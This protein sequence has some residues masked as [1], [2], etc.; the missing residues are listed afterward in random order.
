MNFVRLP[1]RWERLQQAPLGILDPFELELIRGTVANVTGSGAYIALDPHNY[2]RYQLDGTP[3][4][5][6][7]N[8]SLVTIADFA[9][10]WTR[11]ATE[12]VGNPRVIFALMNEPYGMP[13]M[14]WA[15]AAQ[16]AIN[17]IR[18]TGAKQ[19]IFVP[20]NGYTG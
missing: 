6:G 4:I 3:Q 11:L 12:F 17:A 8:T 16:A 14:L 1:F 9:D 13:T 18:A 19:L 20:G 2:A 15:Q 7:G 10:F 5:I